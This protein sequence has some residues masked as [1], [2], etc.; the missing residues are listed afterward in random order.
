MNSPNASRYEGVSTASCGFLP[1]ALNSLYESTLTFVSPSASGRT[2][3]LTF[4]SCVSQIM[5]LN[6]HHVGYILLGRQSSCIL[7]RSG[8]NEHPLDLVPS[9]NHPLLSEELGL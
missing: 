5:C 6:N 3:C 1:V 2:A 4:S 7:L 9:V 8:G